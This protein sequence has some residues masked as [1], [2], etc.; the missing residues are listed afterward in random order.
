M[1]EAG[2][3]ITGSAGG[4]RLTA[5]GSQ[6]RP[7]SDKVKQAL[8]SILEAERA[9]IWD[10]PLL[11]LFAGSGAIGIEALSRGAPAVVMVE[12]DRRAVAVIRHNLEHTRLGDGA[13]V[14]ARDVAAFLSSDPPALPFGSAVLDPP[15]AQLPDLVSSLERLG[16]PDTGW[17]DAEALVAAKHFWKDDLGARFGVLVRIRERRF[18]ETALSVYRRSPE[19]HP[20]G[21]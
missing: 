21:R 11:D 2:R 4:L 10:R 8:F 5:P 19:P 13:R 1:P 12:R 15:Y 20:G 3:V 16:E 9:D 7:V 18:G 17:F 14:E 6:T